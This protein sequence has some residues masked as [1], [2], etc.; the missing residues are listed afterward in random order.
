[1][2][3]EN[4]SSSTFRTFVSR[5]LLFRSPKY[6]TKSLFHLKSLASSTKFTV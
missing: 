4:E 5:C 2:K 1:M 3:L 6:K